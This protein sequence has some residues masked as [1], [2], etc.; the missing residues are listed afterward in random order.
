MAK[1][2]KKDLSDSIVPSGQ[3]TFDESVTEVFDD[4]LARSIP[5][6]KDMRSLTT[7]LACHF[8]KPNT[9]LVDLGCSR[10]GALAPIVEQLGSDFKYLGVEV[11]DPMREAATNR[12]KNLKQVEIANIDLRKKFPKVNASVILSILTLQFI[13]IEYRQEILVKSFTQLQK[14]GIFIFV[15]KILGSDAYLN[16]LFVERYYNLKGVNGYTEE[17]INKKR[18]SLEGILVPV[19]AKWNEELLREAGFSH[20]ECFWRNLNFAGWIA[21]K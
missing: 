11:S 1:K 15:E 5:G 12:F 16:S 4:M 17:Q 21:V 19:T 7:Q 9:Y 13:P 8:A 3:W 20:V 14:G 2:R 18:M 6:Y 10:G